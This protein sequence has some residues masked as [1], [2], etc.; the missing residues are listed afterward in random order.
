MQH[1]RNQ[2]TSGAK[3]HVHL[4]FTG[5]LTVALY[6]TVSA[7]ARRLHRDSSSS[8]PSEQLQMRVGSISK[9]N[10]D[11]EI[12]FSHMANLAYTYNNKISRPTNTYCL[13]EVTKGCWKIQPTAGVFC[14][15]TAAV[16]QKPLCR[17]LSSI[18]YRGG[19]FH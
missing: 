12:R 18:R 7:A 3:Q 2:T 10:E 1:Q 4:L 11:K 6:G 13:T 15:Y 5:D 9:T 8:E 17:N 19:K 14:R 16:G